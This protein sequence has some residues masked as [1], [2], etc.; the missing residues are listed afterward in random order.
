MIDHHCI[1]VVLAVSVVTAGAGPLA[2]TAAFSD[3]VV[4]ILDGDTIEVLRNGRAERIRLNGIDCSEKGQPYGTRAK[5]AASALVFGKEVTLN[6]FGKDKYG[7]TI[8]NVLL[9]GWDQRQSRTRQSRLVLVVSEVR[10]G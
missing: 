6:T 8:A 7:R 10:A 3:P 9:P 5:Q 1:G 2:F 4:R